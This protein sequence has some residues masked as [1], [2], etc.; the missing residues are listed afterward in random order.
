MNAHNFD[1]YT[2]EYLGATPMRE[3]PLEP[4]EYLLPAHATPIA[5]PQAQAGYARCFLDGAWAQVPDFRGQVR[6]TAGGLEVQIVDLGPLPAELLEASPLPTLAEAKAAKLAQIVAG[7][8]AA[9]NAVAADYS[10]GEKL[11]W[12]KQEA[13]AKALLANAE[14]PAPLL[15]GIAARRGIVLTTLRDEVL[16]N[17]AQYEQVTGYVLGS[18]Q[19][20]SDLVNAAT[21]LEEV[22]AIVVSYA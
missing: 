15:R 11:S 17:V 19:R 4:G 3:S 2:G 14:A 21:T 13:E 7:A 12:P 8:D 18:Q 22:D 20:M 16:A 10:Q 5:P 1:R 9:L 6:F